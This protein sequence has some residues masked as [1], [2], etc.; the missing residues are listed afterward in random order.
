M[1]MCRKMRVFCFK[2]KQMTVWHRSLENAENHCIMLLNLLYVMLAVLVALHFCNV[3]LK[4]SHL[5]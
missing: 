1:K 2:R 4:R 3:E 5:C